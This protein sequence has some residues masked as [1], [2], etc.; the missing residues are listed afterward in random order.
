MGL[1]ISDANLIS[2]AESGIR[3]PKNRRVQVKCEYLH[4]IPYSEW[5]A[6]TGGLVTETKREDVLFPSRPYIVS[7]PR[8]EDERNPRPPASS[9]ADQH[10]SVQLT[11]HGI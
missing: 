1:Q 9:A 6:V 7:L 10:T 5:V 8:M 3:A 2:A 4:V 11:F